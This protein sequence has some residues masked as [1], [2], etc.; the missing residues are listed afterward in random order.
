[1]RFLMTFGLGTKRA[2][3]CDVTS[4]M[5]ALWSISLRDFITRTIAA[6]HPEEMTHALRWAARSTEIPGRSAILIGDGYF[7]KIGAFVVERFR[8]HRGEEERARR[9]A[10][11]SHSDPLVHCVLYFIAPH[12]LKPVD[13]QVSF[14]HL[15]ECTGCRQRHAARSACELWAILQTP[16]R[17]TGPIRIY[18]DCW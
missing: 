18:T 16:M 3:S 11:L 9:D 7:K 14:D 12:R 17:I 15:N 6:S 1:M 13:I 2:E 5:R 10:D 4:A 8:E